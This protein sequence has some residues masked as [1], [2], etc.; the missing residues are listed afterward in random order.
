MRPN[1]RPDSV[2]TLDHEHADWHWE[3]AIAKV[4]FVL[5]AQSIGLLHMLK[6]TMEILTVATVFL[7]LSLK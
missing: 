6:Q 4:V 3:D 1:H 7:F 5:K 2:D